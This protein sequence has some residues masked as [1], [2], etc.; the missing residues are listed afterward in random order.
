MLPVELINQFLRIPE[1]LRSFPASPYIT[2]TH[3]KYDILEL[4]VAPLCVEDL[5]NFPFVRVFNHLRLRFRWRLAGGRGC[6]AVEQRDLE[7]VGLPD[8]IR[9]V[10]IVSILIDGHTYSVRSCTFEIQLL[11]QSCYLEV[12]RWKPDRISTHENN[13]FA[14]GVFCLIGFSRMQVLIEG[15]VSLLQ[16]SCDSVC[17]DF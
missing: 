1:I 13:L 7:N 15:L 17:L 16:A 3:P 12:P 14:P 9:K 11:L 5:V 10:Y 8:R 2:V 6:I 4:T